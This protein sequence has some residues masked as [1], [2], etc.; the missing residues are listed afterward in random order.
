M[1]KNDFSVRAKNI[2]S[3]GNTSIHVVPQFPLTNEGR[4]EKK[5]YRESEEK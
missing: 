2:F 1:L 4:G 5:T 3:L